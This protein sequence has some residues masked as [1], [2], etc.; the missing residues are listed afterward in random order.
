ME[1]LFQRTRNRFWEY[2]G[3]TEATKHPPTVCVWLLLKFLKLEEMEKEDKKE[4]YQ[5]R[6]PAFPL[7]KL[8]EARVQFPCLWQE[9]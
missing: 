1:S 8:T 7:M 4:Q 6:T 3:K 5:P 2:S 9:S